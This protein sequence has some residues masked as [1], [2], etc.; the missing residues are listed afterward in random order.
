ML[1]NAATSKLNV[2]SGPE[3]G[4]VL[5]GQYRLLSPMPAIAGRPRYRALDIERNDEVELIVTGSGL[6]GPR[7]RVRRLN[8]KAPKQRTD[9]TLPEQNTRR[10]E[11]APSSEINIVSPKADSSDKAMEAFSERVTLSGVS[12]RRK[13]S[14][15]FLGWDRVAQRPVRVSIEPMD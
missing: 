2:I 14:V 9:D 10:V 15:V 6:R 3:L 11:R 8:T 4:S 12:I 7:Y 1:N 5:D 13:N